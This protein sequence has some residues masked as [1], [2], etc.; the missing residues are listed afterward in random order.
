MILR[1]PKIKL[2]NK[3]ALIYFILGF[4][5]LIAVN[6]IWL[7]PSLNE[8]KSNAANLQ[9]ETAKRGAE[10]INSFID[11]KLDSLQKLSFFLRPEE[12]EKNREIFNRLLQK[13]QSFFEVTLIDGTGKEQIKVSQFE[14]FTES[15]LIDRAGEEYF[16]KPLAGVSLVSQVFFNEKA[17]PYLILAIPVFSF[18]EGGVITAKLKL[19]EMWQ[20]VSALKVGL[21]SRAFVVDDEGKLIADPNPSLVL[22][23]IDLSGL[24]PVKKIIESKQ[25][26]DGL[27]S[28]DRYLNDEGKP[29]LAVGVPL[30]KLNWGLI[31]ERPEEDA[32]SGLGSKITAFILI[33]VLG[34]L[35]V[36]F[37]GKFLV[38]Y[39]FGP[40]KKLRDGAKIIGAGN[41]D[42]RLN[43]RTGDE[44]EEL[45]E[46]FNEMSNQLK[47]SYIH[48]ERKVEERTKELKAQRDRVD[49]SAKKLIDRDIVLGEV[50][51]QQEKALIDAT[52]AR[53][54]AEE[55]RIASLN[56]LED[57]EE[58]RKT[59]EAEKNKIE[60]VLR[61]LTDGLIMLDQFGWVSLINVEA[62]LM[63]NIKK[64]DILSKRLG[65]IEKPNIKKINDVLQA[66][67]GDIEKKE[68]K[69]DGGEERILEISTAP[70]I[71][72]D[73]KILGQVLILHDITREKA[74]ERMKSEFVTIAAHQLRTPL[75]AVKWTLRL[76][77]DGDLGPISKEQ[78]ETLQKGY[79]SNERMINL[80]NDLLNITRIEEGR[81]IF[82]FTKIP[83]IALVEETIE[84][85][86]ALANMKNIKIKFEKPKT[87]IEIS[88]DREKIQ[89]ALQN[90]IENAVNYSPSGGDVTISLS[91]DNMNLT[92]AIADKGMGIPKKQQERIFSKFFRGENAIRMETEGTGLGLFLVKNI[93]EN[94]GGKVWFQ[95][96]E[97]RGSTFYF[98]LPLAK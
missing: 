20:I 11:Y 95:T 69:L 55:A 76:I 6:L 19:A 32:Y 72:I 27:G 64:E 12:R 14:I 16:Q 88:A 75:S 67:G 42:Y 8:T 49:Q 36:F 53:R 18:P 81:F 48:L 84:N 41:L 85:F 10:E 43:I 51:K 62:E 31:I 28:E 13:D 98:S 26:V 15:D 59:Q 74:V 93:I 78:T 86:Q 65:E 79:Q 22:K 96:E 17:E 60:A 58:A 66:E 2:G 33:F 38:T 45:A 1:I 47:E 77:L 21:E 97:N 50:R 39:L 68:I 25:I 89:L 90:L 34:G 3:I 82:G 7:L 4:A 24:A 83:F 92:F 61:S 37:V 71:G 80:V 30:E 91:C 63:L 87:E 70:V 29:V 40:M 46:A 57:I 54:K 52:E 35:S 9:L 73:K 94:H 56:I 23:N 44:I 5:T